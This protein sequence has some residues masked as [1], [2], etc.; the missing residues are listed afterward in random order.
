MHMFLPFMQKSASICAAA[1][2]VYCS[3]VLTLVGPCGFSW[4]ALADIFGGTFAFLVSLPVGRERE[5]RKEKGR[6]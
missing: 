3:A 5:K 4:Q 6:Q 1:L 2:E